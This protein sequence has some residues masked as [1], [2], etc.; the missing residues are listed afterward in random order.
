MKKRQFFAG[1][2][3]VF[4]VSFISFGYYF[5]QMVFTANVLVDKGEEVIYIPTGATF[6]DV[7]DM[8][9]DRDIVQDLVTFSFL[10]KVK[11]YHRL[12]KPGRYLISPNMTNLD[13][14]NQLRAGNQAPV[15]ITFNTI[16]MPQELAEKI[17][18]NLELEAGAFLSELK[19]P[20]R[21]E[22]YGLSLETMMAL[23]IPNTYEVYWNISLEDLFERMHKEYENFWTEER[24]GKAKDLGLS[25]EEVAT[26]ASIVQEEVR[27]WEEAPRVAGLY[28]NRLKQ[29]MPLQAD[30]TLKFAAGDFSIT[31]VLNKHKEIESPYNTYK[32]SGLPPG[33][34]ALPELQALKAVLDPESHQYLYMCSKEDFSNYHNFAT[35]LRDHN[36][37]AA[38]YQ[39]ALNAAGIFR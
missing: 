3:I 4:A 26:L 10:A 12:V 18:A 6:D 24:L 33:P 17:T 31:R 38:R 27:Y 5:Y 35:N 21:A 37:N 7:Q 32:Y 11:K 15:R 25:Q 23:F 19:N 34:V 9:Y 1:A 28:L 2:L 39:S 8:L 36:R 30:P 20:A 16:R 13:L 14:I 29:G 22:K